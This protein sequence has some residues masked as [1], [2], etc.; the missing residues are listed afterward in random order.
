MYQSVAVGAIDALRET[1]MNTHSIIKMTTHNRN[2]GKVSTKYFRAGWTDNNVPLTGS[3]AK[4][5][6]MPTEM[7]QK[8]A[9]N[10]TRRIADN[11]GAIVSGNSWKSPITILAI[12]AEPVSQNTS[13]ALVS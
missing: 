2:T 10:V 4:T 13:G 9:D 5:L 3:K 7:A 11:G 12:S 8:I 6:V 1:T